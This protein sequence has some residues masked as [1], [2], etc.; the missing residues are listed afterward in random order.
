MQP[1]IVIVESVRSSYGSCIQHLG[2]RPAA[3]ILGILADSD[4]AL[5]SLQLRR[6]PHID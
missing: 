4:L 5:A 2:P 1:F 3:P 6:L